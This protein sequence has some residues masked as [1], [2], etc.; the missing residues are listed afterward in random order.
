MITTATLLTTRE[1]EVRKGLE[2]ILNHFSLDPLLWPRTV[3]TYATKGAQIRRGI[4]W[5]TCSLRLA[6]STTQGSPVSGTHSV[7]EF[8]VDNQSALY[9]CVA[10]GTPGTWNQL[11]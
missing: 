10:G 2:F 9:F 4:W 11:V 1:Q 8:Y 7:G 6:P 3:S 5:G